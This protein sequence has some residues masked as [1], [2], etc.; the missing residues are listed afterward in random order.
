MNKLIYQGRWML[1]GAPLRE[2]RIELPEGQKANFSVRA[3]EDLKL[4]LADVQKRFGK[5]VAA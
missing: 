3:G 5:K 2:F 1:P 4:K